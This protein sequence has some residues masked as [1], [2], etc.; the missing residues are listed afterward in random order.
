MT[1]IKVKSISAI[2]GDLSNKIFTVIGYIAIVIPFIIN[3]ETLTLV[4]NNSKVLTS[5]LKILFWLLDTDLSIL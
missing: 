3:P 1:Y 4:L 2:Q 5:D